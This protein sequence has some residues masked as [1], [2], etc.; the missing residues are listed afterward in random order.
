MQTEYWWHFVH[1]W[2]SNLADT[3]DTD[4][5]CPDKYLASVE[6]FRDTVE[7]IIDAL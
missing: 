5:H 6:W 7:M 2:L 3:M 1:T 4:P